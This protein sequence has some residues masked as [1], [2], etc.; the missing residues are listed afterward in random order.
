MG[1]ELIGQAQG[2]LAI[3]GPDPIENEAVGLVDLE[4]ADRFGEGV[5]DLTE[6]EALDDESV[7][8]GR[9]ATLIALRVSDFVWLSDS[10]CWEV[11][12]AI[13]GKIL[14]RSSEVILEPRPQAASEHRI[15]RRARSSLTAKR[16]QQGAGWSGRRWHISIVAEG[17]ARSVRSPAAGDPRSSDT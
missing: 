5:D 13:G 4:G 14:E 1:D 10:P 6:G 17:C 8:Q 12:H 16:G 2:G 15:D 11:D 3:E 7:D 9:A